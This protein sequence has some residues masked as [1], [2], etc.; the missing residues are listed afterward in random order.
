MATNTYVALS[1][2]VLTSNATNVTFT[3][4]PQGYT[5]LRLVMVPASSSGTNGIRM[6]VGNGSL[7]VNS[8]YSGTYMDG[9]GSN[10]ASWRDSSA[11]NFQLS[12]RL[13][14][15]TTLTQVY[16]IDF[17]NYSNTTTHKTALVRYNDAAAASGTS[18]LLWRSTSAINTISFNINTFG[19][20]TGDF[21]TGSTFTLYGISDAGDTGAKAIGGTVTSDAT[22]VYHTFTMSGKFTP[23]QSLT[24][25]YLVVAGGGGGGG[26]GGAGGGAGGFRTATGQSLAVGNYQVIVGA[27]GRGIYVYKGTNGSDSSFNGMTSTGG[28]AAAGVFSSGGTDANDGGS[29]GGGNYNKYVGKGNTPSTTPSQGNDGGGSTTANNL[30]TGGGGGAGSVG[31]TGTATN[32][33]VGGAGATSSISGTSVTYAGGGG[34]GGA[35]GATPA[36]G[37]SG[38]G[39]A[40]STG[41]GVSGTANLG[42]GGGGGQ[43]SG[44][45]GGSGIVIIRY[46]K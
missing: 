29:G 22:Y 41:D 24:A 30:G 10:A 46:A 2:Q 39:G 3:N 45:N 8:N 33:G 4:I 11:A 43:G 28:G 14:I 32:C 17:L 38:G 9:N 27:G 21:I 31:G 26:N 7:D 5:D 18:A 23:T 25:D 19:S 6:R 12:Y 37:G 34:G 13:G 40:G 36:A 35:F 42:G 44:G 1:T 20:S 15:N 16:T